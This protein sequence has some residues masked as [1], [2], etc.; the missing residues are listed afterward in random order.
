MG[1]LV[2]V[3]H[4]QSIWNKKG[5]WTGRTDIDL[6]E[7]G[8]EEAR[9][10]GEALKHISFVIAYTAPLIRTRHTLDEI[11]NILTDTSFPDYITPALT[12]R[13]YG[14]LTGKNKWNVEKKYG[15]KQFLAWRRGWDTPPPNGESLKDVYQRVVPFYENDV[16]PRLKENENV[17]VVSSGNELRAL[18]KHIEDISDKD[19]VHTEIKTGEVWEYDINHDGGMVKKKILVANTNSEKQ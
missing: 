16:L 12:E 4:G 7:E 3:R 13:D 1:K 6:T 5:L 17:L 19:I 11:K 10:A 14:D 8:R 9:K 2:L 18:I 15:E